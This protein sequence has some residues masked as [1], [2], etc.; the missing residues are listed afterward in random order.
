MAGVPPAS[1]AQLVSFSRFGLGMTRIPCAAVL[2]KRS[3]SDGARN[4]RPTL[5]RRRTA[6]SCQTTARRGLPTAVHPTASTA[7]ASRRAPSD[8]RTAS[9]ICTT[10]SANHASSVWL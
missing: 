3:A 6:G 10:L 1:P 9:L 4:P 8:T 2:V 5:A 7:M